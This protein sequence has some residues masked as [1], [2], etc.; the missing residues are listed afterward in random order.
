MCCCTD[1]VPTVDWSSVTRPDMKKMVLRIS[2]TSFGSVTHI[3]G[4]MSN[5]TLILAPK[6]VRQCCKPPQSVL[7]WYALILYLNCVV[8]TFTLKYITSGFYRAWMECRRGI[9]MRKLSV[10]LSVRPSVRPSV[11]RV[12]CDKTEERSV[13]IFIPYERKFSLVFWE[14]EWLVGATPST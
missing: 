10:C 13:Q 3:A 7:N 1:L 8:L 6:H 12:N 9:A 11:K 5:A 2:L 14:E 4:A